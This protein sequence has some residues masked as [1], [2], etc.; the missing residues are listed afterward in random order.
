MAISTNHKPMIYRN[1]YENTDTELPHHNLMKENT[2]AY[3]L[4]LE[5]FIQALIGAFAQSYGSSVHD[6]A[7]AHLT[8]RYGKLWFAPRVII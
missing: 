3:D 5:A 7:T 8:T 1:L 6:T 2:S 4:P